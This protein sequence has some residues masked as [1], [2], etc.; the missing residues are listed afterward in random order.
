[1]KI[2]HKI[3]DST[4]INKIIIIGIWVTQTEICRFYVV[5]VLQRLKKSIRIFLRLRPVEALSL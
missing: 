4:G 5:T 3:V 1:M 2:S